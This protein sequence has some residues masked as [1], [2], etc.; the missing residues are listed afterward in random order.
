M[1]S[2][3]KRTILDTLLVKQSDADTQAH[4]L[5]YEAK[6]AVQDKVDA[7]IAERERHNKLMDLLED[8]YVPC[9]SGLTRDKMRINELEYWFKLL[10]PAVSPAVSPRTP[11][12]SESTSSVTRS[13][14]SP[15]F[16]LREI[17]DKLTPRSDGLDD[18]LDDGVEEQITR[19]RILE[20]LTFSEEEITSISA[21][22]LAPHIIDKL[23]KLGTQLLILY[24]SEYG[25]TP[26]EKGELIK[27]FGGTV[28]ENP[29]LCFG[30]IDQDTQYKMIEYCIIIEDYILLLYLCTY[31]IINLIMHQDK[32]GDIVFKMF[33][34]VKLDTFGVLNVE[35]FTFLNYL[36]KKLER[37]I[38]TQSQG[39]ATA[40]AQATD[41]VT[42]HSDTITAIKGLTIFVPAGMESNP[43]N[44]A[45]NPKNW[46]LLCSNDLFT[47]TL[48]DLDIFIISKERIE[49]E[50]KLKS[51]GNRC[52]VMGG[53]SRKIKK[54]KSRKTRKTRRTRKSRKLRKSRKGKK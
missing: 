1:I 30:H 49:A 44:W 11:R 42:I 13:P 10:T 29:D 48:S 43:C 24:P 6:V 40:S 47:F 21:L 19:L 8:K 16:E 52:A 41:E 28:Y 20:K 36:F 23:N 25:L 2:G 46:V 5:E 31:K 7:V 15:R 18:G 33:E 22:V 34:S 9:V 14:R 32:F 3:S 50:N 4:L 37:F 35:F 27:L 12:G 26:V 53:K 54:G 17:S 39:S 45:I 38:K 51:R